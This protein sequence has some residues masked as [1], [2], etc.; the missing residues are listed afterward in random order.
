MK[1]F[2]QFSNCKICNQIGIHIYSKSFDDEIFKFFFIKYYGQ[3][4]Y[5][6][7]INKLTGK[8]YELLKC[9]DCEFVWQKYSPGKELSVDLYENIIDKDESLEKSKLN[10]LKRKKNNFKEI[11]KIIRHFKEEKINLLDFG[12]GWGHWLISGKK[13]PYQA[14]AFELSPSRK[15]FLKSNGINV[16]ETE[17][18]N[19]F[20][21]YFHYIRLDQ[22]LEHVDNPSEV[23]QLIK[24]LAKK[25][26]V[27]FVSVPD[28]SQIIKNE[29]ISKI[30]KGPV[31]PLEH[32]NC[33]SR[34]SLKKILSTN[35]FKTLNLKDLIIINMKDFNFDLVSVKSFL[36]DIKNYF[37]STSIKFKIK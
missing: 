19:L 32:L 12:A 1:D 34:T 25:D 22:V 36:L 18:L 8:I 33:F 24:R 13:L 14:F 17:K 29:K 35:G 31:Q 20:E 16:L 9:K 2:N 7:L 23:L 6:N 26:C 27:F 37:F 28:G 4:K 10:Y 3:D 30:E 21:N 11:K 5:E 15:F